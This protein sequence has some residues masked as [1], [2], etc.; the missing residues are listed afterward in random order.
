MCVQLC[1]SN[2]C[3]SKGNQQRPTGVSA[4]LFVLFE[5][6]HSTAPPSVLAHCSPSSMRPTQLQQ[7]VRFSAYVPFGLAIAAFPVALRHDMARN[8]ASGA[9]HALLAEARHIRYT[10]HD[11]NRRPSSG[12][13]YCIREGVNGVAACTAVRSKQLQPL[14][15]V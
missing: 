3:L 1:D 11:C 14:R 5:T 4:E 13:P 12:A 10:T 15:C 2:A 6:E 8:P 9:A 7:A